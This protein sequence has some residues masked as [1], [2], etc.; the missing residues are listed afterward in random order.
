MRGWGEADFGVDFGVVL[1]LLSARFFSGG[2]FMALIPCGECSREISDQAVACPH[3]GMPLKPAEKALVS[4]PAGVFLQICA[5][6]VF[7]W[8]G[9]QWGGPDPDPVKGVFLAVFGVVLVW[10]GRQTKSRGGR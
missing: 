3:C 1:S 9:A 7:L 5:L 4:K 6:I 10:L 8:A 2:C